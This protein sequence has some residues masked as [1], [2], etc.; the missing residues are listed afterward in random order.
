MKKTLFVVCP[1]LLM[2]LITALAGPASE[3]PKRRDRARV[4]HVHLRRR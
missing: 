4:G 2:F 3:R 1:I